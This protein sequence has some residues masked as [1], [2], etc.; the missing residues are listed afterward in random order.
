MKNKEIADKIVKELN[1]ILSNRDSWGNFPKITP[2]SVA[3]RED[4]RVNLFSD[5]R[6]SHVVTIALFISTEEHDNILIRT[7]HSGVFDNNKRNSKLV[8]KAYDLF[9]KDVLRYLVV[10]HEIPYTNIY[11]M[12]N[13]TI[14]FTTIVR[15]GYDNAFNRLRNEQK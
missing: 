15:E 7:I 2:Q 9:C 8:N 4:V 14:P 10:V 5:N 13:A 1:S 12:F 6:Y 11:G 3:I